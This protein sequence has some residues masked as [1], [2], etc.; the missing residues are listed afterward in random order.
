MLK[1][2]EKARAAKMAND[3]Q[4][5]SLINLFVFNPLALYSGLN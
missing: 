3:R 5:L 2:D 1:I 4:S